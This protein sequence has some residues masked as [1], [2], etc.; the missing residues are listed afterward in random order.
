MNTIK[1]NSIYKSN[2][3]LNKNNQSKNKIKAAIIGS[4]NIGSDLMIKMLRYAEHLEIAVSGVETLKNTVV[5]TNTLWN[6]FFLLQIAVC[7]RVIF[8]WEKMPNAKW[9]T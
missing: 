4:G 7:L 1:V 8:L 3:S 9:N 6:T 2:N 5:F